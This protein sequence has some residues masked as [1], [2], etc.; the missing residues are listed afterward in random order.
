LVDALADEL[1]A[2]H[3][4]HVA[5]ADLLDKLGRGDEAT[6]AYEQAHRLTTNE[7]ERRHI[8]RLL[9]RRAGAASPRG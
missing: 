1:E 8:E 7:A 2:Y 4:W 5:R 6:R 9:E 3:L